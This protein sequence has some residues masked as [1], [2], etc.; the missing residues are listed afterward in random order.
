ML[1]ELLGID[2]SKGNFMAI[3]TKKAL[4]AL[5]AFLALVGLWVT[6]TSIQAASFSTAN[7]TMNGSQIKDPDGNPFIPRGSNFNG[8]HFVWEANPV[9]KSA[10]VQD[11]WKM[12]AIRLDVALDRGTNEHPQYNF[13]S[14]ADFD[15]IIN[16]YTAKKMVVMLAQFT[17]PAGA[18]PNSREL[19]ELKTWWSE[20]AAKYKDNPYVWFNL[21]NEPGSNEW[22]LPPDE[23]WYSNHAD[24]SAAI[25]ATGAQNTIVYDGAH[26]GQERAGGGND[27]SAFL[28]W[29][30]QLKAAFG[31]TVFSVHV[32]DRWETAEQLGQFVNDVQAKGLPLIIGE[33]GFP[34][35]W[36][37]VDRGVGIR[38]GSL[39][40]FQVAADKQIGL[41]SWHA[42]ASGGGYNL[43]HGGQFDA[44]D[45]L[46]EPTNL[47]ELGRLLLEYLRTMATAAPTA[48]NAPLA[49]ELKKGISA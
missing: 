33:T 19:G 15:T 23:R 49:G 34:E 27:Q 48:G 41:F 1:A 21:Q 25:R 10:I 36:Q 40:A 17:V 12:T 14:N 44:V 26:F 46:T 29:G 3:T 13:G 31:N 45:S 20:K 39:A 11:V 30:E 42:Q 47:T 16:E 35:E 5:M 22:M 18:Y 9:G 32:Y 2:I 24:I 8:P 28:T 38:A 6:G 37:T 43:T 4:I 7:F